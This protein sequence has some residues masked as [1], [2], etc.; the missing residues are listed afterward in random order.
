MRIINLL[1]SREEKKLFTRKVTGAPPGTLVYTGR[2]EQEAVTVHHTSYDEGRFRV[3]TTVDSLPDFAETG[4]IDWYDMRGLHRVDLVEALGK[5]F[6]IH[7][8][9]LEDILDVQQRPKIEVYEGGVLIIIKAFA[10]DDRE[11]QLSIEQVSVYLTQGTVLTFQEDAGDLFE[12]VRNRLET[13]SGRI[14]TRGADYLS[15]ALTD[16]VVD[17]YFTVL[18]QMENALDTLEDQIMRHPETRTKSELHDLRLSLLTLRKSISPV[19][20]VMNRFSDSESPLISEDTQLYVRDLRDHVVQITDLVETYR[21]I[22]NGLY[23]LYVSEISFRMN[24]VMQTLTVVSTIFI[25]LSFL[26]GVYGMNWKVMPELEHP[27]GY[28]ILWGV[29]ITLIVTMLAWFKRNDW[30]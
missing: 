22:T 17:R 24:R 4:N 27:N 28:F 13:S 20:E 30:L 3:A 2:I 5:K 14:R 9:A 23:D 7:P 16:N 21:D 1:R 19:R 11:R 8:L 29:M 15:Y 12:Q 10:F 18:D 25:P 26:V 6:G